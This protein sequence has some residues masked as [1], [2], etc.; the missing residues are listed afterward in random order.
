MISVNIN[1]IRKR[2]IGSSCCLNDFPFRLE[3]Y[4]ESKTIANVF[5]TMKISSFVMLKDKTSSN[6]PR[7][8]LVKIWATNMTNTNTIP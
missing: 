5:S 6:D 4:M 7:V 3:I 8:T 2:K 1:S